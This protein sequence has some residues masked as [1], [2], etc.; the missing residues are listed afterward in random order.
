[1]LCVCVRAR[2]RERERERALALKDS[3]QRLFL[4][5]CFWFTV[6]SVCRIKHASVQW[7][8]LSSP[9]AKKFNVMPSA[10]KVILTVLGILW[11]Y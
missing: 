5:K 2:V 10:L 7:K 3:V 9:S 8:Q 11:E 6:G 1:M 4:K